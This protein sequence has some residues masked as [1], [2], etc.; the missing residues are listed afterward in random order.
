MDN[1]QVNDD[2]VEEVPFGQPVSVRLIEDDTVDILAASWGDELRN[3]VKQM[4]ERHEW[5][6]SNL[7]RLIHAMEKRVVVP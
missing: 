1:S 3:I 4:D 7:N 5:M 6:R 2:D